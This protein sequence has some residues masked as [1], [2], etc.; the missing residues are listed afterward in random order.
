MRWITEENYEEVMQTV[1]EPY[2]AERRTEGYDERVP[3]Q[4]IYYEH[5]TTETPKGVIVISHGFTESVKKFY[6]SIYYMLQAGY[7][8]FGIDHRGHGRSYRHNQDL[9][10]VH[11]EHFRDYVL[12]LKHLVDTVVKPA[13]GSL[14][15]YLY[16]H[17]MGG[18]VGAWIIEDYP[19]LFNKAVLSSP[20]LGLGFGK[21]PTPVV[22]AVASLKGMGAKKVLPMNPQAGFATE[23][24]FENSCDSSE[25]RYLYY[26]K[27]RLA[28]EL[29]QTQA[30]SINWGKE[31]V[32]AT[33]RVT[34]KHWTGRITIPV[35][36]CQ[37]GADTVVKN[38]SQ[39]LFASRTPHCEL[40]KVPGMKHELYM[41]DSEVLITYWEKVF[42]FLG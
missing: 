9:L 35:L 16:C 13:T 5:F 14:P 29:L 26:H 19:E 32:K 10:V 37:A 30:P 12:D 18:C 24:D 4:P 41:T 17:S 39:D 7:E 15:L 34:S 27:K 2:L 40:Y 3:G 36:L 23:P 25:C 21:I 33:K 11:V 8:V 1:V 28:D 22:Y 38:E 6:E 20:M 31:S 42:K